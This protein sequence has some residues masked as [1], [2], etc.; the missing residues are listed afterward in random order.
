MEATLRFLRQYLRPRAS[1]VHVLETRY[2]RDGE[3]L[4]ASLYRPAGR[5]DALPGWVVLHGLTYHGRRHHAL[6]RFARALAASGCAVLVPDMPEWQRLDV[7]PAITVPTI[8][9]AV[10]ALNERREVLPGRTGL[11][12]FSFG[13][14]QALMAA[15]N[16][17]LVGQLRAIAA[18]G[19][20]SDLH[21]LF[22]F[23]V[24]GEHEL[25]GVRYRTDPDPYGRWIMGANYLTGI[26]GYEG[27]RA[28]AAAL[29]RLATEAGCQGIYAG[30]AQLDPLKAD[31]RASLRG[32][33]REVFDLFAPPSGT[34]P[35]VGRGAPL[36]RLLADAALRVDPLLD[37]RPSLSEVY[38]RTLVTHGR[39]DRLVPFTESI[40]LSRALP[41]QACDGCRVTA[42]FAHSGG[43]DR[44][45]G[46][47][48]LT[49]ESARFVGVL[50]RV[51]DLV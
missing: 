38:V 23:G 2:R 43:T 22:H 42:L 34:P 27:A 28:A 29:R 8:E 13:A 18:W 31:L 45:L 41:P 32:E 25:D 7:S 46:P 1:A 49:R 17:R 16:P 36:A 3:E 44:Q 39:D 12:G 9:A 51:L 35:D 30:S 6:D 26:P 20:Y 47:L 50:N 33:Q 15:A 14:T 4:A 11:F 19:G 10:L 37:P 5:A 40:R 21:H 48:G 24:T